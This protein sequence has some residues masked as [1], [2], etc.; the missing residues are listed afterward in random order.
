MRRKLVLITEIISPY[1]IPV[2]NALAQR[3]DVAL[4]V[5]FLA[6]T[7]STQ[8][9]WLVYKDEIRFSY[10]VLPAWRRRLAGYHIL[11]NWGMRAA[12]R[13]AAPGA[14]LCGGY[15]YLASWMALRWARSHGTPF[16][17]WIESSARDQRGGRR[18]VELLKA[19]FI[20]DCSGFVVPG[21]ASREYAMSFG[22]SEARIFTAPNAVDN[23]FFTEHAAEARR[24]AAELR[25]TLGLPQRYFLFVGR[26]VRE[27][28]VF[29]LLSAYGKL[30]DEM[31]QEWGLVY[32]G[33]GSLAA[34][35]KARAAS[36]GPGSILVAGFAQ[37][38]RLASYYAL[39]DVL[40][41][42]THS[43]PWGLVVNEAMACGLPVVATSAAG[44]VPNLVTDGWNGRVVEAGDTAQLASAMAELAAD[45][46]VR[47]DMA[48]HSRERIAEYS[49]QAC[50]AGLAQ[51]ALASEVRP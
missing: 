12:L 21:K 4:H 42:P 48:V 43:D 27:K 29:D 41:F 51:V 8:R 45:S 24:D 26:L 28:G 25:Q 49:P 9:E 18:L 22:V 44:C 30:A 14:I 3:E 23:A 20:H 15:S 35:L 7:D 33:G 47:R 31:K 6:E 5:I 46:E 16:S 50:A 2:F 37:R 39:A 19:K 13:R 1:R 17:L 36:A 10:E 34:E 38:E 11:F 40:V 32:V